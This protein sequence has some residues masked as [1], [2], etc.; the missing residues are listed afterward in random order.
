MTIPPLPHLLVLL[1]TPALPA[2]AELREALLEAGM[3]VHALNPLPGEDAGFAITWLTEDGPEGARVQLRIG[4]PSMLALKAPGAVPED[5]V[6]A[7]AAHVLVALDERTEEPLAGDGALVHLGL[8]ILP[9][10]DAIGARLGHT[11]VW[12]PPE[13]W[14]DARAQV[15]EGELPSGLLVDRTVGRVSADAAGVL[16]SGLDRYGVQEIFVVGDR[17]RLPELFE[18]SGR[19]VHAALHLE[20]PPLDLHPGPHPAEPG[21]TVRVGFLDE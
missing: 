1:R 14:E 19:V 11:R 20:E 15:E 6:D 4:A 16:S 21:R 8:A 12:H 13:T 3:A 5:E 10:V 7:A 9:L 17:E 18:V 2:A